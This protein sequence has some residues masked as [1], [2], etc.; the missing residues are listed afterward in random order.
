M[1]RAILNP[2]M[3]GDLS[4]AGEG[5]S[6]RGGLLVVAGVCILFQEENEKSLEWVKYLSIPNPKEL[7]PK[8]VTWTQLCDL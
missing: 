2:G 7:S 8:A 4:G 1:A 3:A 6:L 5:K